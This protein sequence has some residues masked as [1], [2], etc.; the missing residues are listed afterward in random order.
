MATAGSPETDVD[1]AR[2]RTSRFRVPKQAHKTMAFRYLHRVVYHFYQR[3]GHKAVS[4]YVAHINEEDGK[5]T[6]R[7][8]RRT[9]TK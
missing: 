2:R 1:C 4:A 8:L 5:G 9:R 3:I 7:R 6:L